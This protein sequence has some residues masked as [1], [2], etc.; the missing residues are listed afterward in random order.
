MFVIFCNWNIVKF[1][2]WMISGIS[3]CGIS[4]C[5]GY[6]DGLLHRIRVERHSLLVCPDFNDIEVVTH[7]RCSLVWIIGSP[8]E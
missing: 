5:E 7:A 4:F 3:F 6:F 8:E 2:Y 1:Q